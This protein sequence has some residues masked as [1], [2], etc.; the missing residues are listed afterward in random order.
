M[1]TIKKEGK[2][3]AGKEAAQS[4]SAGTKEVTQAWIDETRAYA[5]KYSWAR[6]ALDKEE[7]ASL[8]NGDLDFASA[9]AVH[10]KLLLAWSKNT[11]GLETSTR[12]LI[13]VAV[14]YGDYKALTIA[15]E[16]SWKWFNT[17]I[18]KREKEA[19]AD[20]DAKM[21]PASATEELAP[22]PQPV[23]AEVKELA[24]PPP[25]LTE[26]M[27]EGAAAKSEDKG[28]GGDKNRKPA[29]HAVSKKTIVAA[30]AGAVIGSLGTIY[31]ANYLANF[32]SSSGTPVSLT[33]EA[34]GKAGN[35][36]AAAVAKYLSA[37]HPAV[38]HVQERPAPVR[39]SN[40]AERPQVFSQQAQEYN[41]R[42]N[43]YQ[44]QQRW[45]IRQQ[46]YM[47]QQR[48]AWEAR[49]Q[50]RSMEYRFMGYAG[51]TILQAQIY[52]AYPGFYYYNNGW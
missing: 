19:A 6:A 5:E 1:V 11:R 13:R 20:V 17:V 51:A 34:H 22:P 16:Q 21:V 49:M 32:H 2:A 44:K 33:A 40:T 41:Y 31:S 45:I 35:P 28:S 10:G 27:V 46:M 8:K 43:E 14:L 39:Y 48:M 12:E 52:H 9:N 15:S 38:K 23:T 4:S 25:A 47:Q 3:S 26:E 50:Q 24:V 18:E 36:I 7:F 29:G 30:V 37:A 42:L